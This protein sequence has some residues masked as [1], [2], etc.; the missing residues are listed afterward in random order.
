MSTAATARN[1]PSESFSRSSHKRGGYAGP[2]ERK[3]TGSPLPGRADNDW[4]SHDPYKETRPAASRKA[5]V[6][7]KPKNQRKGSGKY[8]DLESRNRPLKTYPHGSHRNSDRRRFHACPST[9]SSVFGTQCAPTDSSPISSRGSPLLEGRPSGS[10]PRQDAAS[11]LQVEDMSH[12]LLSVIPIHFHH[13]NHRPSR[14]VENSPEA[15]ANVKSLPLPPQHESGTTPGTSLSQSASESESVPEATLFPT[16]ARDVTTGTIAPISGPGPHYYACVNFR[17]GSAWFIAPFRCQSGDI[18]VVEYPA[19]QSLHM[20]IVTIVNTVK[21][22][23]FYSEENL[24]PDLLTEEEVAVLPRLLRHARPYDKQAKLAL[25]SEDL[26]VLEEAQYLAVEGNVP[27]QFLDA[28]WL[29]DK[30]TITFLVYVFGEGEL[31]NE[32]A[33]EIAARE[34]VEVVFTY[35]S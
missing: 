23:T 35:P 25:R 24:D 13:L 17:F 7:S 27:I 21:P 16:E 18:V 2:T 28:E 29:F 8:D 3:A 20:G 19:T 32:L 9:S 12:N 5:A 10:P 33:D 1:I 15:A 6:G 22:P 26:R 31:V 14:P 11:L 4:R 34:G 30:N